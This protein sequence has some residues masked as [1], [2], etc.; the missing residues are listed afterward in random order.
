VL[1]QA[2]EVF[3]K[4]YDEIG[5]AYIID[6]YVPVEGTYIVV[7]PKNDDYVIADTI[8]IDKKTSTTDRVKSKYME[9]IC[10]ADY[11]SRVVDLDKAVLSQ[12]GKV[13]H[14]NN[15]LSFLVKKENLSNGKLTNEI[16]DNYYNLLKDPK[17][18]YKKSNA[19]ELYELA[20][21]KLGKVNSIRLNKIRTWIK[22]NVFKLSKEYPGKDYLKIFFYYEED[23]KKECERYYILNTYNK[24]E[25]NLKIEN[26]IYGLPNNNMG[27][28]KNKPY[29]KNMTRKVQVPYLVSQKEV[30]YQK[31]FFDYLYNQYLSEKYNIYIEKE[32]IALDSKSSLDDDFHGLFIRLGIYNNE[33]VIQDYDIISNYNSKLNSVFEYENIIGID[34]EELKSVYYGKV[35]TLNKMCE[36][37]DDVFFDE[38]LIPNFFTEPKNL[39]KKDVTLKY[40]ILKCRTALF[41]W[42]YKGNCKNIWIYLNNAYSSLI[43]GSINTGDMIKVA[44][45]LNLRLSLMKYFKGGEDMADVVINI[46]NNLRNKI[47]QKNTSFLEN[48]KQY[49]FAVGQLISY[50][51]SRSKGNKQPLSLANVFF[52]AKNDKYIKYKLRTLYKTYNYDIDNHMY[53]FKG[54]Y[55]MIISYE[56]DNNKVDEDMII[57]GYLHSNLLYE[58]EEN[59]EEVESGE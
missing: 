3:K 47:S 37:I 1:S 35:K 58:K 27:L 57:A 10:L 38:R 52:N 28:N 36:I 13:I 51:I 12:K 48:D 53:K 11:Y 54:L 45:Q 2:L 5:D 33:L 42:F 31:K 41:D 55:A 15:Y 30:M 9:F 23:Y 26:V 46:K 18:K 4:K 22:N 20:E 32:I 25:Y 14:G 59:A 40:N 56:L 34:D 24:N 21:K 50:F 39:P 44:D 16:I 49:F 29:L 17:S 19:S 43:K 6:E 7:K 8:K